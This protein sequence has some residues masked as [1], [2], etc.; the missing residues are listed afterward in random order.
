MS[1]AAERALVK[2][3]NQAHDVGISV[4]YW[5][6]MRAGD[7]L[8]GTTRTVAQLLGGHTAVVW[9]TGSPAC[10]ALTHIEAAS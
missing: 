7:G 1:A 2:H 8:E 9:V 6:G 10:I 3:W 4:R 5:P